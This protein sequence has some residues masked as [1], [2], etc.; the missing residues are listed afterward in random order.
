MKLGSLIKK[1]LVEQLRH[2]INKAGLYFIFNAL[3]RAR[4]FPPVGDADSSITDRFEGIYSSGDWVHR[5]G[6]ESRSGL[7]SELS[8][9]DRLRTLLPHVFRITEAK[10]V[11]DVGCGDWNWMRE[12]DLSAVTYLGFDIVAS[13]VEQNNKKYGSDVC[14]FECLDAINESIPEC[15]LLICREV[16]FHLSFHGAIETLSNMIASSKW[17]LLTCDYSTWINSDIPTGD[18]RALNLE[19][20][21]FNFPPPLMTLSDSE[22]AA[23]RVMGLWQSSS[24]STP[25]FKRC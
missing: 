17:I 25:A 10:V 5:K 24:I 14:R 12:V 1:S 8:S 23:G 2:T 6:Q 9:T 19:A 22:V 3:R 21:P 11:G 4:G 16:L 13:V 15:D 20:A 18:F 7:G